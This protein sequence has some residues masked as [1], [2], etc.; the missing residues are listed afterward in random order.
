MLA[1]APEPGVQAPQG[2]GPPSPAGQLVPFVSWSV[3][4]YHFQS[5]GEAAVLRGW[6]QVAAVQAPALLGQAA[7]LEP[8]T[9]C[10]EAHTRLH[11]GVCVGGDGGKGA[12]V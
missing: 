4:A 11:T 3:A 10:V 12:L 9:E 6:R 7:L 8:H 5:A 2:P 1:F